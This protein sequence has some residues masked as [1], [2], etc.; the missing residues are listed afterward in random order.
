MS[1]VL[2]LNLTQWSRLAASNIPILTL[3]TGSWANPQVLTGDAYFGSLFSL[4]SSNS[5]R[6]VSGGYVA[7]SSLGSTY[8]LKDVASNLYLFKI[9]STPPTFTVSG[10]TTLFQYDGSTNLPITLT[11]ATSVSSV[12]TTV[13]YS[14][15]LSNVT[16]TISGT[17]SGVFACN[18]YFAPPLPPGLAFRTNASTGVVTVSGAPI[19][20]RP[21]AST[22]TY[23]ATTSDNR[24]IVSPITFSVQAPRFQFSNVVG[25]PALT[26]TPIAPSGCNTILSLSLNVPCDY[27][28]GYRPTATGGV[29]L[30]SYPTGL[31]A[32]LLASNILRIS[33]TPTVFVEPLAGNTLPAASN[34][35]N[36]SRFTTLLTTSFSMAPIL[37]L[38]VPS[39]SAYYKV[40][41]SVTAPIF[42]ASATAYPSSNSQTM[43]WSLSYNTSNASLSIS[44]LGAVYGTVSQTL[45]VDV[46]ASNASLTQVKTQSATITTISDVLK[47][48]PFLPTY[49][50]VQNLNCNITDYQLAPT[51]TLTVASG[52]TPTFSSTPP[53]TGNISLTLNSATG[54]ISGKVPIVA[55]NLSFTIFATTPQGATVS[56]DF[57]V[58]VSPDI[59]SFE[60]VGPALHPTSLS[61]L[62]VIQ[63][64]RLDI[65][66]TVTDLTF[67]AQA[68]S[69]VDITRYTGPP[70]LGNYGLTLTPAGTLGGTPSFTGDLSLVFKAETACNT[71][72]TQ[73]VYFKSI[74]EKLL[75]VTPEVTDFV[76]D[77]GETRS[78]QFA[79]AAFSGAAIASWGLSG[80]SSE[81]K[82]LS[83]GYMTIQ[84]STFQK[85][86]PFTITATTAFGI[87]VSRA[88]TLT[89]ND[90]VAG[91]FVS[92]T[93]GSTLLLLSGQTFPVVTDPAGFTL[94]ATGSAN[95]TVS[96]SN[97]VANSNI[98]PPALVA[99]T[100]STNLTI[101]IRVA[102]KKIDI[103]P[104]FENTNWVEFVPIEPILLDS[105]EPDG[106]NT[107]YFAVPAPP[108]GIAWNPFTFT[109]DGAP[110]RLTVGETFRI[111]ASDGKTTAY[112][113]VGYSVRAPA[114]L[115]AFRSPSAYTNYIRQRAIVNAAVH[116]IDQNAVL[117]DPLIA[118]QTGPYPA[119]VQKD[120]I[121]RVAGQRTASEAPVY[122]SFWSAFNPNFWS[123][124]PT[125][126][127]YRTLSQQVPPYTFLQSSANYSS[128]TFSFSPPSIH[129]GPITIGMGPRRY[130]T[131]VAYGFRFD[132]SSNLTLTLPAGV[133]GTSFAP[134]TTI[135]WSPTDTYAIV[136]SN[137]VGYFFR[138]SN[139][140][141]RAPFTVTSAPVAALTVS[142]VLDSISNIQYYEGISGFSLSNPTWYVDDA[143]QWML[144]STVQHNVSAAASAVS[145]VSYTTAYFTFDPTTITAQG[146]GGFSRGWSETSLSY[147][148]LLK[149]GSTFGFCN[150]SDYY[151]TTTSA[152]TYPADSN[153]AIVS[154]NATVYFLRDGEVVATGPR[155]AA[156]ERALLRFAACNNGVTNVSF[157]SGTGGY[158]LT[159]PLWEAPYPSSWYITRVPVTKAV[160]STSTTT[161]LGSF[162]KS[163]RLQ[164]G[165]C[166]ITATSNLRFGV[167]STGGTPEFYF[168]FG[169]GN[170]F[171]VY[172]NTTPLY[173]GSYTP[174]TD[175]FDISYTQPNLRFYGGGATVYATVSASGV[176]RAFVEASSINDTMYPVYVTSNAPVL[177]RYDN[178]NG[179]QW[180]TTPDRVESLTGNYLGTIYTSNAITRF[181]FRPASNIAN[182]VPFWVAGIG[183]TASPQSSGGYLVCYPSGFQINSEG[184]VQLGS[185]SWTRGVDKVRLIVTN[186]S[187]SVIAIPGGTTPMVYNFPP[188]P[189]LTI[190]TQ[191]TIASNV[192]VTATGPFSAF[193]RTYFGVPGATLDQIAVI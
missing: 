80:A 131:S 34:I 87:T 113:D 98:Y 132:G 54:L 59:V 153:L 183:P 150:A 148:F 147:G 185:C 36:E 77:L 135:S 105:S 164:V 92:P 40:P 25:Y 175:V 63:G 145:T 46:T 136:F 103:A 89:V 137:A 134:S 23:Y 151:I 159:L 124:T 85:L 99:L 121:C 102:G 101:P 161:S 160:H 15:L 21:V 19:N 33:G 73:V 157:G 9:I 76:L 190:T 45:Q 180:L 120:Y 110:R 158:D 81:V 163:T 83:D 18:A 97:L 32:T 57:I 20:L 58:G 96:G 90:P 176:R 125:E 27:R 189:P 94:S 107:V 116:A 166:S 1:N 146:L 24:Q 8:R 37:V 7:A 192:L 143:R 141:Y 93:T 100:A 60:P 5:I 4:A 3:T 128:N 130:R 86:T 61:S 119:D 122:S 188:N 177:W 47:F 172:S 140:F 127:T 49:T 182:S 149:S 11:P 70:N 75:L 187:M 38:N 53:L 123:L 41:Y 42:Q 10:G 156:P 142:T 65:D 112:A 117:P 69:R 171:G 186:G 118:T 28:I 129:G 26:Y 114:Y 155:V 44:P 88:A 169:A 66:Y 62:P 181:E 72:G 173:T 82:M 168:K 50:L 104:I 139:M 30:G 144:G 55:S 191:T 165:G 111:Y 6:L 68:G 22:Y 133:T 167:L 74:P 154:S 79:G 14:S 184:V 64:R 35:F 193:V 52:Q 152:N 115:R 91:G 31:T 162:I 29:A 178:T 13:G 43:V 95:V 174:G 39:V 126:V 16:A 17:V 109:L 138:N 179:A 170:A 51:G 84:A 108:E 67:V 71:S 12:F 2:T 106:S 48:G 78:Y 56:K